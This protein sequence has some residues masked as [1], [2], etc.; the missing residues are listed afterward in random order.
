MLHKKPILKKQLFFW[1]QVCDFNIS[2]IIKKKSET[3]RNEKIKAVVPFLPRNLKIHS[4]LEVRYEMK[5]L[6]IS[7]QHGYH[8]VI[9]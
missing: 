4:F 8:Q 6:W 9:K 1:I 3:S 7:I 5:T 2:E